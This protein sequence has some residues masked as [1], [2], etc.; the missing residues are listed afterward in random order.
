VREQFA[1]YFGRDPEQVAAAP[2]RVN[3]IGEY[4]DLNKGHV[5]PFAT[6]QVTVAAIASRADG[7][8]RCVSLGSEPIEVI[9]IDLEDPA[10]QRGWAAY[11]AAVVAALRAGGHTVAGA[12][13]LVRSD[14]PI[15]AGLSS[16]AALE[17]SVA[18]ALCTREKI[19]LAP[20]ELALVAQRAENEFVGVPCGI[21]DQAASVCCR[22]GHALLLDTGDLSLQQVPLRLAEQGLA[23]VVL[24]TRVKHRLG[25]S[26]YA[27][28]RDAFAE[29][30]RRLGV[31]TLREIGTDDL[32]A[33]LG[34]LGDPVLERRVR[35][36]VTEQARVLQAAAY[37]EAGA[38]AAVAPL[39][40][41]SHRSL[42]DDLEVSCVELDVAVDAARAA[43]ALGA[44]MTGGGFGG[45]A[46]ALAELDR[47]DAVISG[48]TAAAAAHGFPVPQCFSVTPGAGAHLLPDA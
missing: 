28:R 45:S 7:R 9:E 32:D 46:I 24:D 41:A 16:S 30:A 37:L 26:G 38:A 1:R 43:G 29:A 12:D 44:R 48:V 19:E 17:C 27:D 22:S 33:A 39:L 13:V 10:P 42:R 23:V 5:L 47:V 35:H 40:D 18:L 6:P 25:D 36:V 15:G 2:G 14:V 21:M 31:A 34:A 20:I 3:L 4:T 11:P 8:M